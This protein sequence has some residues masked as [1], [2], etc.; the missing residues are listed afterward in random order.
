[1]VPLAAG[2]A[3]DED[4][5]IF[6]GRA[7]AGWPRHIRWDFPWN[8]PTQIELVAGQSQ[9]P[10]RCSTACTVPGIAVRN[11]AQIDNGL[12]VS[13]V[14]R[15][16][17]QGS[18]RNSPLRVNSELLLR[19]FLGADRGELL[20]RKRPDPQQQKK[21]AFA[22]IRAGRIASGNGRG[23]GTWRMLRGGEDERM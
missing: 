8:P 16:V 14:G 20:W 21:Q 15:K 2:G 12:E 10:G 18:G 7:R 3:V 4:G 13:L 11:D 23:T 5:L 6:W 1:M 17:C 22:A 19:V 9:G